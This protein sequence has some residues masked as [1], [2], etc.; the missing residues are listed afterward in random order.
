MRSLVA[1]AFLLMG[2]GLILTPLISDHIRE[3]RAAYVLAARRDLRQVDLGPPMGDEYRWTCWG[4]GGLLILLSLAQVE[5][6]FRRFRG[7]KPEPER[8]KYH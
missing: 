7:E 8:I 3:D 5:D 4:T 2:V 6:V 1:I